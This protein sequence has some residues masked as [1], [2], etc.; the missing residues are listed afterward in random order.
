[1]EDPRHA[2]RLCGRRVGQSWS[3]PGVPWLVYEAVPEAVDLCER[4]A[5]TIAA[6]SPDFIGREMS[7]ESDWDL[8]RLCN[9]LLDYRH[10]LDPSY[11]T[12]PTSSCW[13]LLSD[14][15]SDQLPDHVCFDTE[16]ELTYRFAA[17]TFIIHTPESRNYLEAW[18]LP[19]GELS[20]QEYARKWGV[21]RNTLPDALLGMP[22]RAA[23]GLVIQRQ[24]AAGIA[25]L[26]GL[27]GVSE[28]SDDDVT[29]YV[30]VE[31]LTAVLNTQAPRSS[32]PLM[33][34]VYELDRWYRETLLG[35]PIH[36]RGRPVGTATWNTAIEFEGAVRAAVA[37]WWGK[38]SRSPQPPSQEDIAAMVHLSPRA[39]KDYL[40]RFGLGGDAWQRLRRRPT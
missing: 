6:V 23:L 25:T 30:N 29:Q 19:V 32:D 34:V 10:F 5:L 8:C 12:P 2:C 13:Q 1:M 16:A 14:A 4:C 7:R 37:T 20:L 11:V 17:E 24:G 22:E 35:K 33:T 18:P 26:Y 36:D 40:Q 3:V 31:P 38:N 15:N 9:P 27:I 28:D 39:F 21:D